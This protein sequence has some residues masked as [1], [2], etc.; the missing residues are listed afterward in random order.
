ML[1]ALLGQSTVQPTSIIV[2]WTVELPYKAFSTLHGNPWSSSSQSSQPAEQIGA[3]CLICC[4][5]CNP[6]HF[7]P[8]CLRSYIDVSKVTGSQKLLTIT[9]VQIPPVCLPAYQLKAPVNSALWMIDAGWTAELPHNAF[10]TLHGNP[11]SSPSQSRQPAR[12]A[13]DLMSDVL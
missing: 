6:K 9:Q 1:N 2:G 7:E 10:S 13:S 5:T 8:A 4:D 12:V 3:L 11:G